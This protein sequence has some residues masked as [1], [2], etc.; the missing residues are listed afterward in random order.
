M[1]ESIYR[2]LKVG[3]IH[4]MA[5]PKTTNFDKQESLVE[6]IKKV[7]V[8]DYFNAMEITHIEDDDIRKK[9]KSLLEQ[10]HMTIAYGVQPRLLG[11]KLNPNHL[12]EEERKKAE[13]IILES[14]DEAEY[15]G[16]KSISFLAGKYDET[17][18][19]KAYEQLLKTT[20]NVCEYAK[21]KDIN[22]SLEVFDY[23][24]DKK[25]LIGPATYA[26]KFAGEVRQYVNNFGLLVDLSHL[27]QTHESSKFAIQTLKP[28]IIHF[29]IGNCVIKDS[30]TACGDIHP[31]FGFPNGVNDI[32][33]V[34]EFLKVMKEEGF[35]E[36]ENPYVMS[37]E[38]KPWEDEDSEIIIA[39][40]KRT[41]NRAWALL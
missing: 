27:P 28:Y 36:E 38:V 13:K 18:K 33:E 6:S 40:A 26:A 10:S 19:D 32:N 16:A 24:F 21:T 41:L 11:A 12:D 29:H 14:I 30:A 4:F 39:N 8:D 20:K 2:Y 5:Y 15:L 9:V 17:N 3:L 31:R 25:V 7:L 1:K 34:K 37:F 22:V 23:D 35:F